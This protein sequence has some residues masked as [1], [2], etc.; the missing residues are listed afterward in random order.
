MNSVGAF[1]TTPDFKYR[2]EDTD[3]NICPIGTAGEIVVYSPV[4][5]INYLKDKGQDPVTWVS[6][7]WEYRHNMNWYSSYVTSIKEV[8]YENRVLYHKILFNKLWLL[9]LSVLPSS[10][11]QNIY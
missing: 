5:M 8:N 4:R 1:T 2:I 10:R 9:K 3:G 11:C 7:R 6:C